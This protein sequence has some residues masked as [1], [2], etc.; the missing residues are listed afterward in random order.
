MQSDGFNS[1]LSPVVYRDI[2]QSINTH[3]ICVLQTM[4]LDSEFPFYPTAFKG[5][6]GI[7]FSPM[8]SEYKEGGR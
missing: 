3:Y 4:S 2:A 6:V 1:A 7:M 5:F 8:V